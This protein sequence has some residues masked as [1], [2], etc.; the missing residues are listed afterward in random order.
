MLQALTQNAQ[1]RKVASVKEIPSPTGGWNARDDWTDMD[2]RDAIVLDNVDVRDGGI[3]TRKGRTSHA[4]G[5]GD[6]VKE[7]MTWHGPA[8]DKMFA[9]TGSDVFDVTA[10]G[11]V[12][13]AA[14]TGMSNG[15]W[16]HVM[17]A[18]TGANYLVMCNGADG[19]RHFEGTSWATPAITGVTTA[20]LAFVTGHMNRLWFVEED[21]L[22]VWYL[23]TNAV[24]G[25]A[26]SINFG[27]LCRKGGHMEVMASWSRDG[28]S[29]IDDHAV[30]VTSEGEALVYLGSDPSSASTWELVGI[31]S[32]PR[33][34]G[35]R[36]VVNV[37]ADVGILTMQ[38]L[39]PLSAILPLAASGQAKVAAT[40]KIS[41][42]FS[43]AAV[44]GESF[45][46]WQVIESQTHK[47]LIINVPLVSETTQVQFVF[48][49]KTEAWSRFTDLNMGCWGILI[50]DLYM[51][52]NSGTIWKYDSDSDDGAVINWTIVQ[53]FQDLGSPQLKSIKRVRPQLFTISGYRPR[54]GVRTDFDDTGITFSAPASSSSG[55]PWGSPWGSP[56]S[57]ER[58]NQAWWQSVVGEGYTIAPVVMGSTR[59]L[60]GYN[61]V[62]IAY[63]VGGAL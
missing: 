44:T 52:D 57:A 32:I 3:E 14:L 17:Y 11:A 27:S 10:A 53:A 37:G 46:D 18:T 51:G 61:G 43:E 60:T 56:W 40:D 48:N 21:T 63:E 58:A 22:K 23:P 15:L 2:K 13:A 50:T 26:T 39:L 8:S 24:A 62:K 30:F 34:I 42:A 7:I 9:A 54:V 5:L 47:L 49:T 28:G 19:V 20:N 4:T 31:F 35:R 1:R 55:T 41:R 33:P 25:A 59:V 45:T 16:S 12:G 38:G 29:G 6:A 36:C